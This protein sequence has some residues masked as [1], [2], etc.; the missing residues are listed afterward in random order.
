MSMTELYHN[1][2]LSQAQLDQI[3]SDTTEY[4]PIVDYEGLAETFGAAPAA[5][6]LGEGLSAQLELKRQTDETCNLWKYK[7]TK[8]DR[9]RVGSKLEVEK[10]RAYA[11]GK[12]EACLRYKAKQSL[13][14]INDRIG[15][16]REINPALRLSVCRNVPDS[17]I[18]ALQKKVQRDGSARYVRF[19]NGE[20]YDI[21]VQSER[22]YGEPIEVFDY[23]LLAAAKIARENKKYISGDLHSA[24]TPKRKDATKGNGNSA[25]KITT[26]NVI[27]RIEDREAV[28]NIMETIKPDEPVLTREAHQKA[29][30][31]LTKV[32]LDKLIA[33]NIWHITEAATVRATDIDRAEINLNVQNS[34]YKD[35][36]TIRRNLDI[37]P[38]LF[39][40]VDEEID[41]PVSRDR[42]SDR[43]LAERQVSLCWM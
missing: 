8:Y 37:Q 42:L 2:I 18:L 17:E 41:Y 5:Q 4:N 28:E 36:I 6:S 3:P 14:R 39:D 24:R 22:V 9:H 20:G 25:Y 1:S 11:C 12:C 40:E 23:D 16:R 32:F 13:D 29:T 10:G 38:S 33:A 15:T 7:A 19:Y 31:R 35:N 27:T 26:T 21:F 43:E 34:P 30:F